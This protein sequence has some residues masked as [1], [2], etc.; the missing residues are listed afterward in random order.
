MLQIAKK[1][2]EKT[3]QEEN[4]AKILSQKLKEIKR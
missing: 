3:P 4:N 1:L 2:P